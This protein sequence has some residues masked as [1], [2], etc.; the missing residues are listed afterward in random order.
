MWIT[1]FV[2]ELGIPNH[3]EVTILAKPTVAEDG[4]DI[5]LCPPTE[6]NYKKLDKARFSF[7]IVQGH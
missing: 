5:C 1:V 6:I 4:K 3:T 7:R 2:V